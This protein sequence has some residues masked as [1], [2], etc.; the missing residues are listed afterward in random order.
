MIEPP[1]AEV[2]RIPHFAARAEPLEPDV[3]ERVG[4]HL[5]DPGANP[6]L[7]WSLDL[8]QIENL[9]LVCGRDLRRALRL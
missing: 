9:V 8:D 3:L 7:A 6:D 5:G 4:V 2:H 1:P